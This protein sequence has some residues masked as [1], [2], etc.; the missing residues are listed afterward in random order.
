[1]GGVVIP[2]EAGGDLG[3]QEADHLGLRLRGYSNQAAGKRH[4]TKK[5]LVCDELAPDS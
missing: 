4:G 5:R 2:T 1:M 3:I